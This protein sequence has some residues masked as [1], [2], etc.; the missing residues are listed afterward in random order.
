MSDSEPSD[1]T[2]SRLDLRDA[3]VQ[4][5]R[6]NWR[7]WVGILVATAVLAALI[8][9]FPTSQS[10]RYFLPGFLAAAALGTFAV[11]VLVMSGK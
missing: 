5:I 9:L 1:Q 11:L 4:T 8:E 10:L 2:W 6:K 7:A 3:Q